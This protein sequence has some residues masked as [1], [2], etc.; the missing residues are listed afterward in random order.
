VHGRATWRGISSCA[1][2][3]ARVGP[4]RAAGKAELTR[5]SHGAARGSERAEGTARCA[6]EAGPRGRDKRAHERGQSVPTTRSHWAERGRE[7]TR[8][9]KLSLTG[10]THLSGDAGARAHGLDGLSWAGWA[11]L[12]FS[13]SLEFLIAFPFLFL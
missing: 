1:R 2:E 8:G 12:A 3:C 9:R 5:R 13:I 7:S 10:G 6:D 4:R 11:A